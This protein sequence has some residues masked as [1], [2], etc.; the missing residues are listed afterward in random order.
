MAL[1]LLQRDRPEIRLVV[2]YADTAQGH[3]GAIYQAGNWS[4]LGASATHAI[5]LHGRTVH[6]RS[7]GARYGRGGQSIPW[8]RANHDPDAER[9]DAG[10]KHRYF[11]GLDPDMR[12]LV[13]SRAQPFPKRVKQAMAGHPP[14]QRQG[15]TDPHAPFVSM[16]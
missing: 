9:V 16:T 5:R 12:A 2:S 3:H 10:V 1:R 6:P 14:A 7:L 8:L 13:R 4:Y 15:G 11:L